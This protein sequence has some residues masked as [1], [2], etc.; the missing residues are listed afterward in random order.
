MALVQE[1]WSREGHVTG[2]N[3]P[4]YIL[5]SGSGI[6]RPTACFLAEVGKFPK[7]VSEFIQWD[8][9]T[10]QAWCDEV[11]LSVNLDKTELFVFTRRWKLPRLFEPLFCGGYLRRCMSVKYLGVVLDSRPTCR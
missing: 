6:D 10:V 8:L 3:I 4:S 5:F 11:G 1:P 9:H 2:L 7:P